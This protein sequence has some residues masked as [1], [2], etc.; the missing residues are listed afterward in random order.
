[1]K[2]CPL[3]TVALVAAAAALAVAL[4]TGSASAERRAAACAGSNLVVWIPNGKGNGTAGSVYYNLS[5][6][7]SGRSACTLQGY[8]KITAIT[9]AGKPLGRAARHESSRGARAIRLAPGASAK[10]RVR[11]TEAGNYSPS[12]CHPTAA[13]GLAVTA[14]GQTSARTVP[15]PFEGCAALGQSLL[16]TSAVLEG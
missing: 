9:L 1:M 5:L 7:N 16:G 2:I 8:P 14:P 15:L 12:E 10:V 4:G 6:T 11:I 13:G 3:R